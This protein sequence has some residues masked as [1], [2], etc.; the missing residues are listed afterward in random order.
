M[1]LGKLS[2]GRKFGLTFAAL[3][4]I[5]VVMSVVS[6]ISLRQ[7]KEL[8]G[9]TD[10]THV[11]LEHAN[12][13]LAAVVD[14]ETG[15][16]GFLVSGDE[17]FLEPYIGG[18]EVFQ[19]QLAFLLETTSDN[20][21]QQERLKRVGAAEAKW[22]ETI[23]EPQIALM[24]VFSTREQARASEA[25]G[26][27]KALM[28]SIRAAQGEF[29]EAEAALLVV[30]SAAKEAATSFANSVVIFGSLSLVL[31]A[32][33]TGY[34]LTRSISAG[35]TSAVNI[36][37][38]VA[39]GNLEVNAKSD[40]GDELGTLLNAMD[41]MVIDLQGMSF[42]AERIADGDL[43]SDVKQRSDDDRLALAL[44]SMLINLRDVITNANTS[45]ANV[46]SAA[47]QMSTTSEELSAG[48]SRQAAAAEQASAS[49]E[50]MSANISQ[51]ADNAGQTEKIASQSAAD[52][53]TSGEAV[54]KA[55]T[56]MKTIADKINIIQEIARQTDLLALNAAVEAARAGEHGKG[57]A[58][59]ASE[60]RKLAERS[61]TA[62]AEIS[63]LS[64]ETVQVSSEAGDML[65]TLVPN[66]QHTADLVQEIS[67]ATREQNVGAEQINKAIRELDNVIQQNASSAQQSATTSHQLAGQ[68]NELAEVISYFRVEDRRG[69]APA[70]T[71]QVENRGKTSPAPASAPRK[72]VK[73]V[74]LDLT[75]EDELDMEFERHAS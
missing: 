20:P 3:V 35:L 30:R 45:S 16:R 19:N 24:R 51:T 58:V 7:I 57:F 72:A 73:G 6:F 17:G 43:S 31:F 5:S 37:N 18:Q 9:W 71:R 33:I 8:D 50:E 10:H 64:N 68:A 25:S 69:R 13:M 70:N 60:V 28:D 66:I 63:Q 23:A 21:A 74:K 29:I 49:I 12:T 2:I 4:L 75:S 56:A 14:Q 47:E 44:N 46:S 36:V 52:A 26:A 62:A 34:L 59:V 67:A 41:T 1:S 15:M 54:A 32:T 40:R 38:E 65:E 42:A 11:V 22:R 61:Q 39:R 55:V 48:A 53:K 27:G